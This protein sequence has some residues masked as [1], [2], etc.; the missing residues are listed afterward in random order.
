MEQ[1][2]Q[3][4][5]D[6]KERIIKNIMQTREAIHRETILNKKKRI[7]QK[8]KERIAF[9]KNIQ[10]K[11]IQEL[12]E[13]RLAFEEKEMKEKSKNEK[14][15]LVLREE[16]RLK[17][18]RLDREAMERKKTKKER[19]AKEAIERKERAV[20]TARINRELIERIEYADEDENFMKLEENEWR[21]LGRIERIAYY[22]R[23]KE[24]PERLLKEIPN[25]TE[26]EMLEKE[27]VAQLELERRGLSENECPKMEERNKNRFFIENDFR[28]HKNRSFNLDNIETIQEAW[29][30]DESFTKNAEEERQLIEKISKKFQE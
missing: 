16:Q 20:K 6:R 13:R 19:L 18:E 7:A 22:E 17:K 5:R 27:L 12:K 30:D 10:E 15:L 23:L 3:E 24:N 25:R 29:I 11:K 4:R 21:K 14:M 26:R 9:F 8:E 2:E 28:K 1:K